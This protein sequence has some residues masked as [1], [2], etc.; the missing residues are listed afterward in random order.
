MKSATKNQKNIFAI[1]LN[2]ILLIFAVCTC[3]IANNTNKEA[4]KAIT[5]NS[6]SGIDLKIA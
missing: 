5:P 3:G 1:G 2:C 6:L 4:N